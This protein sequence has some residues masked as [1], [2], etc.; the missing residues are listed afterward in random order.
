MYRDRHY[1]LIILAGSLSYGSFLLWLAFNHLWAFIA[2]VVI[3]IC[4]VAYAMKHAEIVAP[5]DNRYEKDNCI[6][7]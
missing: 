2:I 1:M 6:L 5:D 7:P 4:C 3:T